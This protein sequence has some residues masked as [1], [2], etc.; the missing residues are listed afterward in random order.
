GSADHPGASQRTPTHPPPTPPAL[1]V[2]GLPPAALDLAAEPVQPGQLGGGVV[3]R[4]IE[5]HPARSVAEPLNQLPQLMAGQLGSVVLGLA[6]ER[7]ELLTGC[8]APERELAVMIGFGNID[9]DLGQPA[10]VR[11]PQAYGSRPPVRRWA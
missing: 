10:V 9:H 5:M 1:D 4:D 3:R 6:V 8:P 11:H 2:P 7:D